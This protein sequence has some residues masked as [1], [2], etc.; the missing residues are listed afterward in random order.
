MGGDGLR[1][2]HARRV[3]ATRLPYVCQDACTKCVRRVHM[4]TSLQLE[5]DELTYLPTYLLTYLLAYLLTYLPTYLLTYLEHDGLPLPFG[6]ARVL[7][8][9]SAAANLAFDQKRE[10][11]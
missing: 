2:C 9:S 1:V 3:C 6:V 11:L 4:S 7:D 8:P 5:H 10:L